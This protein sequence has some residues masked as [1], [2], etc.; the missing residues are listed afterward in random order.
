MAFWSKKKMIDSLNKYFNENKVT[1]SSK[2][3]FITFDL[4]LDKGYTIYPYIKL[5]EENDNFSI[6]INLRELK[7]KNIYEKLNSF[8]IKSMYLTAKVNE[9][10]III[11][12]YNG[13]AYHDN[14]VDILNNIIETIFDL[15]DDID[16][17]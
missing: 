6:L 2:D 9:D 16:N 17:L 7:E 10:G 13:K 5:D 1:V 3:E 11:L 15:Q 14:I 12:E 4:Y 8:N